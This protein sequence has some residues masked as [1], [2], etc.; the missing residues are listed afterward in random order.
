MN[1][2]KVDINLLQE[3]HYRLGRQTTRLN[4][5]V[6]DISEVSRSLSACG[7]EFRRPEAALADKLAELRQ[8]AQ[9]LQTLSR[10]IDDLMELYVQCESLLCDIDSRVHSVSSQVRARGKAIPFDRERSMLH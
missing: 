7:T 4:A 1:M 8:Y 6:D 5:I 3:A 9:E 10:K 2:L